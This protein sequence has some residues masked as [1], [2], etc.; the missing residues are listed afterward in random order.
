MCS[1]G[2][3][4]TSKKF[5]KEVRRELVINLLPPMI[6]RG[7]DATGIAAFK[8]P[9]EVWIAKE[10]VPSTVFAPKLARIEGWEE[11]HIILLH[12]RAYTSCHPSNN[13][14]NHPIYEVINGRVVALVHNGVVYDHE[15]LAKKKLPVDSDALLNPVR[16]RGRLDKDVVE[17][18]GKI[19]ASMAIVISDG[20]KVYGYRNTN[21]MCIG[22]VL[23]KGVYGYIVASTCG[24]V[25]ES[26]NA[27]KLKYSELKTISIVESPAYTVLDFVDV[28]D[29]IESSVAKAKTVE[30]LRR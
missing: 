25:V 14:C 4:I 11:A 20:E 17:E 22:T 9:S 23:Y 5:P 26:I 15:E 2:A 29:F 16:R 8:S 13:Y 21:P 12:A 1:I 10:P 18:I 24:M 19:N 30:G 6:E 27:A 7:S 28:I 3:V